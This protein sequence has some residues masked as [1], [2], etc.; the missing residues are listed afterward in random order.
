MLT[1]LYCLQNF[2]SRWCIQTLC[3]STVIELSVFSSLYCCLYI[4]VIYQL[5]N[6]LGTFYP[7]CST[8]PLISSW[9]L[10]CFQWSWIQ[11]MPYLETTRQHLSFIM[12][13][14]FFIYSSACYLL[15]D[16]LMFTF[17]FLFHQ[18]AVFLFLN[19]KTANKCCFMTWKNIL[20]DN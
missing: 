7:V 1:E 18:W 2:P 12:F 19:R 17:S 6:P 14:M 8:Q 3:M 11:Q 4:M 5:L 15:L 10:F 16:L 20:I 13:C 9:T